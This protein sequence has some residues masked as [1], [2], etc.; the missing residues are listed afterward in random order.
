M[1]IKTIL[2]ATAVT[3]VTAGA[4]L[5]LGSTSAAAQTG[6]HFVPGVPHA[7]CTNGGPP[8]VVGGSGRRCYFLPTT[9][10]GAVN[11]LRKVCS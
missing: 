3:A 5:S 9:A 11:G 6:C 2:A 8:V 10:N 1:S 7:I 4:F